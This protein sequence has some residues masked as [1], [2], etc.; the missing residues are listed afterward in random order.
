MKLK[1]NPTDTSFRDHIPEIPFLPPGVL[2]R[3]PN[4]S[5]G[6]RPFGVSRIILLQKGDDEMKNLPKKLLLHL[7]RLCVAVASKV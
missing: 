2:V 7:S 4:T 6:A 3:I 1:G 5:D